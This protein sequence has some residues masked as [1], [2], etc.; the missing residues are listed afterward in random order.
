MDPITNNPKFAEAYRKLA[1]VTLNPR[2]HTA[3]NAFAHSEMVA[4]RAGALARANGCSETEVQLLEN[5]GRAHDIGKIT[6]TAKPEKSLGVLADCQ[7]I[8]EAFLALVKWHDTN[9]PWFNSSQRGQ[10]PSNKAWQRLANELD[11]RLLAL[12]M[13]ADRVDAPPGWRR[14]APLQWFLGEARTRKLLG[15][16]VLDIAGEPSEISA[17]GALV[18][19][20]KVLV[21]RVRADQFELPKGGIEWDELPADAAVRETREEAGITGGLTVERE[22]GHLDYVVGEGADRHDK[23]VRY[24][25]LRGAVLGELP[26]RTRERR[27]VGKSDLETLPL[28]SEDLRALALR[29]LT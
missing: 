4:R 2:R 25:V 13:V 28:V 14:N 26:D 17:G 27:W 10:P 24:F 20:G 22:L 7:V 8:D 18:H 3:A 16:L 5:L 6:G 19:D 23:R 11:I 15:D 9:L 1:D 12:F 29:S 21:I